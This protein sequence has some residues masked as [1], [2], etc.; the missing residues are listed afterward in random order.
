MYCAILTRENEIYGYR[1]LRLLNLHDWM[2]W[3][4]VQIVDNKQK[5]LFEEVWKIFTVLFWSI[6]MIKI[7]FQAHWNEW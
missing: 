3:I 7:G 5:K 2:K 4:I 1:N 6:S